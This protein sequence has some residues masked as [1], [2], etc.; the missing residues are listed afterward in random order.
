MQLDRASHPFELLHQ[1]DELCQ[2]MADAFPTDSKA[3]EYW[4]GI[5]FVVG[6]KTVVTPWD[7]VAEIQSLPN[8]TRVPGAK[9]WV[10]GVANVRGNLLP[11]MDLGGFIGFRPKSLRKQRILVVHH[12]GI[13]CGLIVDDI[14]GAMSFEQFE[15]MDDE[16]IVNEN[17]KTTVPPSFSSGH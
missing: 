17:S 12:D 2:K 14:L 16:P 11:V 15:Q 7:E 8:L 1:M 4:K 10:K 3:N 13:Y 5:G 9:D 6:G